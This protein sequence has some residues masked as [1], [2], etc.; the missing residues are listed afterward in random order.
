MIA[1][2]TSVAI[3]LVARSHHDHAA[4]VRWCNGQEVAL[5]GH[6]LAATYS[7]LTGLPGDARAWQQPT[8]RGCWMPTS[9]R[10]YC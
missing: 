8:R 1:V 7:V 5:T 10:R 6:S 9:L 4:V 3:P 2:D